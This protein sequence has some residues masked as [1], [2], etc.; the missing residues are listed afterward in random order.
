MEKHRGDAVTRDQY[1]EAAT[2][3]GSEGVREG[4]VAGVRDRPRPP[5]EEW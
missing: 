3:H 1:S 4:A 2:V 5:G